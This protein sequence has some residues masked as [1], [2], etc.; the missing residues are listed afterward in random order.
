MEK[1]FDKLP[2]NII[3]NISN[4]LKS[5]IIFHFLNYY[6]QKPLNETKDEEYVYKLE[7]LYEWWEQEKYLCNNDLVSEY[8]ENDDYELSD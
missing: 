6:Y 7:C 5:D 8:D 4:Y 3:F 2:K 1:Q